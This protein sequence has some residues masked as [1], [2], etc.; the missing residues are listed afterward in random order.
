MEPMPNNQLNSFNNAAR[1][2]PDHNSPRNLPLLTPNIVTTA[3][4]D[5]IA[6]TSADDII[7]SSTG[8]DAMNGG[9]G[10]DT[11]SYLSMQSSISVEASGV[12]DKGLAGVDHITNIEHIIAPVAQANIIDASTGTGAASIDV[13]LSAH[14]LTVNGIPGLGTLSLQMDNFV[15]V[16]GTSNADS[17]T[18]D[19]GNN[20]LVGDYRDGRQRHVGW[21]QSAQRQSRQ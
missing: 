14:R 11:V 21:G 20:Y 2:R 13:D 16:I 6:G 15:N 10:T 1:H 12:I 7:A 3:G 8:N 19:S 18:G 17:I 5:T 4:D 9:S